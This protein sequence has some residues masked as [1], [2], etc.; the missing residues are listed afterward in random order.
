MI[1]LK[2]CRIGVRREGVRRWIGQAVRWCSN[3][4]RC[5]DIGW[6]D[7]GRWNDLG[8]WRCD[9]WSGYGM[10][11]YLKVNRIITQI[12]NKFWFTYSCVHY[13]WMHMGWCRLLVKLRSWRQ[14]WM[15]T[16][17][18]SVKNFSIKLTALSGLIRKNHL[19]QICSS[20][21]LGLIELD[22]SV[23]LIEATKW[24]CWLFLNY[25]LHLYKMRW[26]D[27]FILNSVRL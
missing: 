20:S 19:P 14:Q 6:R 17:Q 8:C 12:E 2:E 9:E 18:R 1:N 11:N 16:M 23:V 3:V 13:M 24:I 5:C 15:Q 4:W 21:W 7:V 22:C 27:F 10:V 25:C 26:S